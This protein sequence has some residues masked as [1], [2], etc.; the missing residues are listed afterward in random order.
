[1]AAQQLY[2]AD[3]RIRF[4]GVLQGDAFTAV[5]YSLHTV[6]SSL[7]QQWPSPQASCTLYML[8]P[9]CSLI[10]CFVLQLHVQVCVGAC[11]ECAC[12]AEQLGS[13]SERPGRCRRGAQALLV[14]TH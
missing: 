7:A 10:A 14:L 5:R 1:M 6:F 13:R 4:G 9:A 2:A 8:T 3:C 11:T 12:Q